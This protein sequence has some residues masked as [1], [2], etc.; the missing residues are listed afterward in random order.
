[1]AHGGRKL[2]VPHPLTAHNGTRYFHA[3]LVAHNAFVPDTAILAAVTFVIFFRPVNFLSKQA[4]A[5]RP[6]GAVVNGLR[7]GYF[8]VR[9]LQDTFG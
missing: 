1:M 4:I 8:S 6:L 3:A 7:L 9:P 5:F 2:D